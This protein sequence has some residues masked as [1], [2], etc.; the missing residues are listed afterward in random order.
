VNQTG[1]KDDIAVG[2]SKVLWTASQLEDLSDF[3]DL[4]AAIRILRPGWTG[5]SVVVAWRYLRRQAWVDAL[6]VLEDDDAQA[7]R[8]ALHSALMA[9]CL[10][11]LEDP[12]WHGY[13]R[14]AADQGENVEA[15][16]I[17][18]RLLERTARSQLDNAPQTGSGAAAASQFVPPTNWMRA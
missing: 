11:G 5:A 18:N 9:V 2:L 12:L 17:A 8:S 16:M 14:N 1:Q 10:F 13:A 3:D 6:R 4:L 7:K 15:A